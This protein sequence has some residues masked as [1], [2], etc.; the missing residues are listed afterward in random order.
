MKK[1]SILLNNI[2]KQEKYKSAKKH[3]IITL[4]VIVAVATLYV[5]M[6]PAITLNVD[7]FKLNLEDSFIT[8]NYSW[9]NEGEYSSSL[10]LKLTYEN[11]D[12]EAF[13]GKNIILKSEDMLNG[14]VFSYSNNTEVYNILEK[15]DIEIISNFEE[16]NSNI[17]KTIFVWE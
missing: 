6:N 12:K 14:F 17:I 10:E 16:S 8:D 3:I 13:N 2:K 4:S 7:E 9:K 11:T 15:S 5:L 1:I